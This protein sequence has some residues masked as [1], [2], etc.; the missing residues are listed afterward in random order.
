MCVGVGGCEGGGA[1][2]EGHEVVHV[3]ANIILW[4]KVLFSRRFM[5][6]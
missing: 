4:F 3:K 2:V 6:I 5:H 1:C